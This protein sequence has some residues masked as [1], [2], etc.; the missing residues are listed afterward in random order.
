M[1]NIIHYPRLVFALSF[2][3]MWL[4]AWFG[5]Y[6]LRKRYKLDEEMRE[7]FNVILTATLTLLAL[8]IAFTFS[9]AIN[10]YDQRKNLE[11]EEANAIGTEYIRAD[12]LPA[13][14]A[15]KVRALLRS[16]L[17]Q[18]IL[19]YGTHDDPPTQ[20]EI[21]ARTAQL[22]TELWSAIQ[23]PAAAQ[24]TP[25]IALVVSGMNDVL[26]SQGYIQAALWNRI[27]T[28]AWILMVAIAICCNLLGGY[29]SHGVTE[30]G[31]KLLLVLPLVVSIAFM[32]VAD[33]DTP[34][35]GVIRVNPQN[36]ISLAE[37]LR[38]H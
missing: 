19:F 7:D 10:R 15:A 37:S 28:E 9:M 6:I 34:R 11:A 3:T 21:N 14:D 2:V 27:P 5:R 4:S 35:H 8:I 25:I 38:A 12:L 1:N 30:E 13:A 18:R 26:N 22:Q 17:D 32:L 24:P 23:A 33:I 31:A 16:Y 36:L 20:V 29:G